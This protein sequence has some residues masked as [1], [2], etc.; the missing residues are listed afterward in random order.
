M[1]LCLRSYRETSE[2]ANNPG[3]NLYVT[4]LSVRV[5]EKDLQ[6]HFEQEGKVRTRFLLLALRTLLTSLKSFSWVCLVPFLCHIARE[7]W[8]TKPHLIPLLMQT[9]VYV[10]VYAGPWMSLGCRSSNQRVSW[11]W[12]CDHGQCQ[13]SR[14]VHQ[15]S[16]SVSPWR[17]C[18]HSGEGKQKHLRQFLW[19]EQV[20]CP[21]VFYHQVHLG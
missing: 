20:W 15:V 6:E 21:W 11:L 14:S 1:F 4:G 10:Y 3:N 18:Y 17:T 13:G 16:A 7:V 5:S 2:E 12:I 19:S 9:T 8:E